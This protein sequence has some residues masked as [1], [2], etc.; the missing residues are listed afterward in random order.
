MARAPGFEPRMAGLE[1]ASLAFKLTPPQCI[2]EDSNLHAHFKSHSFT[3]CCQTVS[4]SD[5]KTFYDCD[6]EKML[7][8]EKL[9]RHARSSDR[10]T[11]TTKGDDSAHEKL[12]PHDACRK[13]SAFNPSRYF[14]CQ[15]SKER[16][17]WLPH[18]EA[19]PLR[20][21]STDFLE[22]WSGRPLPLT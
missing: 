16:A 12:C 5:A 13:P 7:K 22:I 18:R 1:S 6:S 2:R 17:T 10:P 20:K 11:L 21:V 3:G 4:A 15:T 19:G 8:A 9:R 14:D